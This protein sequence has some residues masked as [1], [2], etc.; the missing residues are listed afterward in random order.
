MSMRRTVAFSAATAAFAALTVVVAPASAEAYVI[1]ICG[2]KSNG[3]LWRD[4]N[5][6]TSVRNYPHTTDSW[7]VD[8]L[9]TTYSWF[10]CW[11]EGS[12][13]LGRQPHLT[14]PP[15]T[16]TAPPASSPRPPCTRRPPS[17]PTPAPTAFAAADGRLSHLR[18]GRVRDVPGPTAVTATTVGPRPSP[19]S[20]PSVR[21]S[22]IA[23]PNW[24]L[25]TG[26]P[27]RAPS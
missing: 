9:R 23:A 10:N 16:T 17:T 18:T 4:N 15:A 6:P 12:P 7:Q 21:Y 1:R 13:A 22:S 3:V 27:R 2:V 24:A 25:A 8:T 14:R 11:T 26:A 19:A 20:S 5:A